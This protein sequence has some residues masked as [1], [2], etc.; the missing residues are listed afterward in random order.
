MIH[1]HPSRR[2]GRSIGG[3]AIAQRPIPRRCGVSADFASWRVVI[4]GRA[5]FAVG[6]RLDRGRRS[7]NAQDASSSCRTLRRAC[8]C[9]RAPAGRVCRRFPRLLFTRTIE[10]IA[11]EV[12]EIIED[13][14]LS[15]CGSRRLG[16]VGVLVCQHGKSEADNCTDHDQQTREFATHI[17][18]CTRY[19]DS[20]TRTKTRRLYRLNRLSGIRQLCR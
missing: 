2:T 3:T 7:R 17:A 5:L 14:C 6:G 19:G 9:R 11:P 18:T 16:V 1:G 15:C 8:A 10:K 13:R 20:E 4:H 12:V